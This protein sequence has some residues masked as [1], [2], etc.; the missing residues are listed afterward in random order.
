MQMREN[1]LLK[2]KKRDFF[3]IKSKHMGIERAITGKF[4]VI[5]V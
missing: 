3:N 5:P 2:T 1:F 4:S